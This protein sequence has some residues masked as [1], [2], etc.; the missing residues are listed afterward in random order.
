MPERLTYAEDA[1]GRGIRGL[2]PYRSTFNARARGDTR[3]ALA[4]QRVYRFKKAGES[5]AV[6]QPK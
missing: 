3:A 1:G 6:W 2:L 4:A 5:A